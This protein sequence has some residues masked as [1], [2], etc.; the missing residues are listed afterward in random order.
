M[1]WLGRTRPASAAA[2]LEHY[3]PCRAARLKHHNIALGGAPS[4]QLTHQFREFYNWSFAARAGYHKA[5]TLTVVTGVTPCTLHWPPVTSSDKV[6]TN[7]LYHWTHSSQPLYGRDRSSLWHSSIYLSIFYICM[8]IY[9]LHPRWEVWLAARP[10]QNYWSEPAVASLSDGGAV[11]AGLIWP[12][13]SIWPSI[14][15]PGQ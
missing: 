5:G 11:P 2:C 4:S 9:L 12:H 6:L 13:C 8:M 7:Y 15:T 3:F 14:T 10:C 1:R